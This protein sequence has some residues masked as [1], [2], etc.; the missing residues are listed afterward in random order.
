MYPIHHETWL[1]KGKNGGTT[2]A[3]AYARIFK[4]PPAKK[5]IVAEDVVDRFPWEPHVAN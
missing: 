3:K 1:Y 5:Q 4:L 2:M